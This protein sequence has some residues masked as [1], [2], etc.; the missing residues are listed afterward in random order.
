M[1]ERIHL[2]RLSDRHAIKVRLRGA[3]LNTV[4]EEARCP[5]MSECFREQTAT[6]LI[7]GDACTRRCAFCAIGSAARPVQPPDPEEPARLARAAA[8]L[9]M[10][11][12]V[13][14]S[15]TRDDLPDGGASHFA[16][17][18]EAVRREAP[19]S[20]VEVLVPDFGGNP[21]AEAVLFAARPDVFNHNVETVPRLYP[22]VRPGACLERSLGLL[23]R[24][25]RA[26]LHC[27]SG[28]MVGLGESDAEVLEV[29][30]ELSRRG[31]RVV[32][33]GQYL[34]PRRACL[35]VAR[36]VAPSSYD[37]FRR[38]GPALSLHVIAGPRVRSSYHARAVFESAGRVEDRLQ[39][40]LQCRS[41]E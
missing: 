1:S 7:L 40:D 12:V 39:T 6:F 33:I 27:K 11:H 31:C 30:G 20:R 2:G 32:T 24:A 19:E 17:A 37:A 13:I 16:A 3:G 10:R 22:I 41:S 26:G 21:A 34:R 35:P 38:A 14:T 9:G 8:A 29:L 15:V 18:I 23:E 25:A 28:L 36:R 5:N 4:C